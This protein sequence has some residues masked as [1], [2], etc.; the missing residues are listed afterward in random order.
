[1]KT[2]RL[3]IVG[4][5]GVGKSILSERLAQELGLPLIEEQAR[6]IAKELGYTP[7]TMPEKLLFTF[8]EQSL[9][10]H[11][12][13]EQRHHDKGFIADRSVVD[14]SAYA[15]SISDVLKDKYH[16]QRLQLDDCEEYC[17][18]QRVK[19]YT[20]IIFVPIMFGLESDGER[21]VSL[22]YQR[23]IE[24]YFRE[25]GLSK[26]THGTNTNVMIMDVD[27][28]ELRVDKTLRWLGVK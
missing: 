22:E 19:W 26:L 21:H 15:N 5:H 7:S 8:Q 23:S 3:A 4:S 24:N 12:T 13:L 16:S 27:G 18:E 2:I 10:S 1:M 14:Y 25:Q 6:L 17:V 11:F 20:H 9:L 28:I